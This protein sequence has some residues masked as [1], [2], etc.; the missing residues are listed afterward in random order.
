[1]RLTILIPGMALCG[2]LQIGCTGGGGA[3]ETPSASAVAVALDQSS[4]I[5]TASR[6]KSFQA[7]VT[8]ASNHSVTWSVQEGAG[9]GSVDASGLYAAPATAGTYHVVAR[10]VA[11]PTRSASAAVAVVAAPSIASFTATPAEVLPGATVTLTASFGEGTALLNPGMVTVTSGTP[12]T[13]NPA[14]STVYVLSVTN[15][16]GT[17]LAAGAA[18][19]VS[20]QVGVGVLPASATVEQGTTQAFQAMVGGTTNQAVTW[21]V[22]EGAAGGSVSPSGVYT[23]PAHG[24]SYHVVATS[25]LDPAK[26]ATAAVTVPR[27]W[28]PA[29]TL[30]GSSKAARYP[31]LR[32]NEAGD[33]LA[34]YHVS[35]WGGL[36][37]RSYSAATETWGPELSISP[38]A[39]EEWAL[40]NLE[41][42]G[43][44]WIVYE[45]IASV[46]LKVRRWDGSAWTPSQTAV[47][48]AGTHTRSGF[49]IASE[50]GGTV[51][52]AWLELESGS[53]PGVNVLASVHTASGWSDPQTLDVSS[54]PA[55]I[56]TV[57][58]RAGAGWVSWFQSDGSYGQVYTAQW[59]PTGF[60]ATQNRTS[61]AGYPQVVSGPAMGMKDDG[62]V[63][64]LWQGISSAAAPNA[65]MG[66]T[67]TGS[68][69]APV[70]Q[71]SPAGPVKA[72][73]V[74]TRGAR[75]TRIWAHGEGSGYSFIADGFSV[76]PFVA[77][78]LT[79]GAFVADQATTGSTLVVWMEDGFGDIP[80]RLVA[81]PYDAATGTWGPRQVLATFTS[82]YFS[83]SAAVAG[84]GQAASA[85]S[86]IPAGASSAQIQVRQFR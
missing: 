43:S 80:N 6:Q 39:K 40:G 41:P 37:S 22:Q 23:P 66:S 14:I 81:A 13:V 54:S 79:G 59:S 5:V 17:T 50:P 84:D 73:V 85:W 12:V 8:G 62:T 63:Y 76:S 70:V 24:G 78:T 16:A 51:L 42:D 48:L 35:E 53:S 11:D 3:S 19:T 34:V 68:W 45:E 27:A 75:A 29:L 30:S 28:Q 52:A 9:G 15:S 32:S 36:K 1:M 82:S 46:E 4:A 31:Q 67:Y 49:A 55:S 2:L 61:V 18:V 86:S 58:L 20:G 83:P 72:S 64:L 57:A 71:E 38:I 25:V 56:P 21:S 7:T 69:S 47:W 33:L 10:S 44:A 74:A 77:P 26:S 60:A 65:L